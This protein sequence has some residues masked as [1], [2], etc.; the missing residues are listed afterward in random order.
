MCSETHL[1]DLLGGGRS[2][3]SIVTAR[4]TR[5][6]KEGGEVRGGTGRQS[7]AVYKVF[8]TTVSAVVSLN[9]A[10]W[11]RAVFFKS[12]VNIQDKTSINEIS[13]A[14]TEPPGSC[15]QVQVQDW[16]LQL[17]FTCYNIN[18]N[19]FYHQPGAC[20]DSY[21]LP[22]TLVQTA[23]YGRPMYSVYSECQRQN[24]P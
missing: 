17:G 19:T 9:V 13:N 4:H 6:R 21:C 20:N 5:L 15:H 22:D 3:I 16:Q 24:T 10:H 18:N 23:V 7:A 12:G 8:I 1:Q 2:E 14:S 11:S